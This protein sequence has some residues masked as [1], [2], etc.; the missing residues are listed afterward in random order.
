METKC[1]LV[2]STRAA[3]STYIEVFVLV[4]V[5]MACSALVYAAATSLAASGTGG[6]SVAISLATIKQGANEA[7]EKVTVA[8]AG[9]VTLTSFTIATSGPSFS[10]SSATCQLSLLNPSTGSMTSPTCSFTGPVSSGTVN[11]LPG[12]SLVATVT[13]DASSG[14][15]AVGALY[16]VTV[17]TPQAAQAVERV[18]ATS[19]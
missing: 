15:F 3:V 13:I 16:T 11:L 18:V 14:L 9:T 6:A 19:A 5:V 10:Y 7:I 8:N 12:Q 4:A 1:R 17:S 2:R